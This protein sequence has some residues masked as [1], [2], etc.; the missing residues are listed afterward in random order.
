MG[1]SLSRAPVAPETAILI[2]LIAYKLVLVGIGIACE[3]R[4]RDGIDFFLGGRRLGP[5]VASISASASSS[6][7]WTLLG[8]SG[9][10]F[11]QGLSAVWILPGC[12][13]GFLLNWYLLAPALR[14]HPASRGVVTVAEFLAGPPGSSG[15]RAIL[16]VSALV[17]LVSF[18]IYVASQ[19]QGAA[20]AFVEVFGLP[21]A[22]S[23]LI[24]AGVVLAYTL[25][26]GFWAVSITDTLQGLVMAISAC[27][28][29]A[30]AFVAVGGPAA[31][32]AALREVPVEGYCSLTGAGAS[33]AGLGVVL[34]LLGIGLGYPGQPHVVNRFLALRPGEREL[35]RARRIAIAWAIVVYSG[36]LILGWSGRVLFAD[37]ADRE[38]VFVRA[39]TALLHPAVAGVMLAAVLSAI[40]ST[41]DSQLLV[42]ASSVTHDLGLG[43]RRILAR[44]RLVVFLIAAVAAA[45]ALTGT[46]EIFRPVLFAW[47][48]VGA[49]FGPLLL[50]TVLR[51]PVGPS[52]SLLAMAAGFLLSIAFYVP[53]ELRGGAL[54]RIGPYAAAFLALLVPWPRVDRGSR[55]EA[56]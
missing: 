48:A 1:P 24:G 22:P 41:A 33:L 19:F 44:S 15:R 43:G 47:N 9:A 39:A 36:M 30:F 11:A 21:H 5:V 28:L 7:A 54:E 3:R 14:R 40:M 51:G 20:K 18:S 53:A 46:R 12:V 37:L 23:L 13:G 6:S 38:A 31:L 32:A 29:P 26:G 52:R 49:A 27:V 42:A 50:V 4:T 2:T 25:L 8:V 45:A 10:A 55:A 16:L 34:G 35:A 17:I 56:R